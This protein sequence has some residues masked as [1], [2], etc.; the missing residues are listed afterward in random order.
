MPEL[1]QTDEVQLVCITPLRLQNQGHPISPEHLKP[2][3]LFTALLRR[4]SLL[5]R[6]PCRYAA[7]RRCWPPGLPP[8]AERLTD[9]RRL[10][11]RDWTR[12]S[13][14]QQREMTLGGVVGEWKLAGRARRAHTVVLAR[15]VASH[16]QEH[17]DGHGNVFAHMLTPQ[18]IDVADRCGSLRATILSLHTASSAWMRRPG[19]RPKAGPRLN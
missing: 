15:T 11:W 4:T 16:R 13:S 1:P 8:L 17:H 5:V 3:A 12:F 7:C 10:Q 2:H 18:T 9:E 14:R 6:A 19:T